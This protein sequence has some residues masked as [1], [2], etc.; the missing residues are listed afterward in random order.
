MPPNGCPGDDGGLSKTKKEVAKSTDVRKTVSPVAA[1]NHLD[2]F[3]DIGRSGI[4]LIIFRRLGLLRLLNCDSVFAPRE[5][6]GLCGEPVSRVGSLRAGREDSKMCSERSRESDEPYVQL[7]TDEQSRLFSLIYATISNVEETRDVLQEVNLVLWRKADS[8]REGTNFGAWAR[9]I[10]HYQILAYCKKRRRDR[11]VFDD[12]LIGQ[13]VE[14]AECMNVSD[15]RTDALAKCRE[16][17]ADKDRDMIRDRYAS[18][19]AVAAI[20][21]R[22]DRSA[23]HVANKLFNIRH[24][25]F[26]CIERTVARENQP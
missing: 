19:Q 5:S 9:T 10:A 17:L 23:N 11:H 14:D 25:L 16:T 6:T 4:F 26:E 21:Q 1:S 15:E 3:S 2:T 24:R 8:Y 22:I 12:V 18:N 7:I 13:L 20:A